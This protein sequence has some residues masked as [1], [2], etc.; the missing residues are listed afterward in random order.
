MA[1]AVAARVKQVGL[2]QV[3]AFENLTVVPLVGDGR[4]RALR[5][6]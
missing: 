4:R 6:A 5:V 1:H 2:G 3:I